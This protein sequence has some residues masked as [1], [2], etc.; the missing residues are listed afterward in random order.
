MKIN[1]FTSVAALPFAATD[2]GTSQSITASPTPI[3]ERA[4]EIVAR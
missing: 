2:A 1:L 4:R 3:T